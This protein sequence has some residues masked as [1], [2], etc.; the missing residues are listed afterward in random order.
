MTDAR[1]R[2]EWL[3]CGPSLTALCEAYPDDWA[4]IR[5][6]LADVFARRDPAELKA[7]VEKSNVRKVADP[8]F[9]SGERT[10]R[11]FDAF[12]TE[13]IRQRM[14]QLA[15]RQ[16]A[17]S[18]ATGVYAGKAR[19]G[20]INGLIAQKLLFRRALERK[21]VSL[22]WFR[23]IWPLLWQKRLLMPL[24]EKRGIWCFY[25]REL[26]AELA[27]LIGTRS[28]HEIAAGDGTLTRFLKDAG[29]NITASDDYSWKSVV[30]YPEF[31]SELDAPTALQRFKPEVVICS[32][33]PSGNTFERKVFRSQHVQLYI[34]IGSESRFI[35]GNWDEYL[36]QTAFEMEAR[37]DLGKLV[38]PPEL[39][40]GVWIFRRKT[41]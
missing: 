32:W 9:L 11:A 41:G 7:L 4:L 30:S 40:A 35:T 34:V 12:V 21:P 15:L 6:E 31:V 23:L 28:C 14:R 36:A 20:W 8:R 1:S 29:I 37:P 16:Y 2:W 26:I 17:F 13:Q 39:Q 5:A 18:S 10:G 22:R 24:V 38:L 19:F 25:S 27:T 33:P 3:Q